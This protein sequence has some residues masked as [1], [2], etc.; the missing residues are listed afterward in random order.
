MKKVR[1]SNKVQRAIK[2]FLVDRGWDKLRPSDIAK[3]ISIEAAEL[4]E[5]FQWESNSIE[6]VKASS[7]K[8]EKIRKELADVLIYCYDMCV[9]L[10]L[11]CSQIILNKL[12]KAEEKYPAELMKNRKKEPGTEDLYH[13]I[14]RAHRVKE[15]S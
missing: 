1:V 12:K 13:K 15:N 11:D 2:K 7:E 10:D 9:L 8:M 3:S 4:L 14:K 5:I 6:E